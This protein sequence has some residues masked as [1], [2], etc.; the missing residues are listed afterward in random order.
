MSLNL[1]QG[2]AMDPKIY[3]P[4]HSVD[5]ILFDPPFIPKIH[6]YEQRNR[7]KDKMTGKWVPP[8]NKLEAIPTPPIEDYGDFWNALCWECLKCLKPS[9]WF[10]FKT[11]DIT[12]GETYG[13][14]KRYMDFFRRVII[15]DKKMYGIGTGIRNQHETMVVYRPYD[16]ETSYFEKPTDYSSVQYITYYPEDSMIEMLVHPNFNRGRFGKTKQQDHINQTP[17]E[18]WEPIIQQF[19]PP[20]GVILDP[21]MGS[22]SVGLAVKSLNKNGVKRSYLGIEL[23]PQ[24]YTMAKNS[25]FPETI[26]TNLTKQKVIL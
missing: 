24:F 5:L 18:V 15:W 21:T 4:F 20:N 1:I 23:M 6:T 9:G 16:H 22:G 2:N 14:M 10:I 13:L 26:L 7:H 8:K 19:C 25:L 3:P 12:Y 11:D 17:R